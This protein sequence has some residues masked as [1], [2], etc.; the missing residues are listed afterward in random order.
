M[1]T[2]MTSTDRAANRGLDAEVIVVGGGVSGM[3]AAKKIHDAGHSVIVVEARQRVGGRTWSEN[4]PEG[5]LEYGG[6]SVGDTHYQ[7]LELGRS[8]GLEIAPVIPTG[9]DLYMIDGEIIEAPDGQ[10]PADKEY[11]AELFSSIEAL[12]ELAKSVGYEAPWAASNAAELDSMTASSW[13]EQNI[14]HPVVQNFHKT[15]VNFVM[16]SAPEETSMLYWAWFIIQCEGMK[17][18]YETHGGAQNGT[19]I[20]GAN[21]LTIRIAEQLGSNVHLGSPARAVVQ[22]DDY[23]EVETD[24]GT[25]RGRRAVLAMAPV[26]AD[27]LRFEPQLPYKRRQL[28][29][30]APMAR[31]A[32]VLTRYDEPFWFKKGLSG[33]LI[34]CDRLGLFTMDATKAKDEGGLIAGF[35]SGNQHDR[36]AQMSEQEQRELY[37]SILVDA[38]GPE[39]ANPKLFHVVNWEQDPASKGA[40]VMFMPPGVMHP[41]GTAL[42]ERVGNLF[43]AGTEASPKWSGYMEGAVIAGQEA[44]RQILDEL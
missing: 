31:Q 30:R 27:R 25:V 10:L 32:K 1:E 40:P 26:A 17:N 39:A 14:N 19:W 21:Q 38:F 11:S 4:T 37:L 15:T 23:V 29:M 34:D 36:W 44:A 7:S 2:E 28:Q 12:D 43:I 9:I 42:R 41:Y 16:G 24:G 13:I 5:T 22:G 35:V 3:A 20:G 33:G 8:L 18:F 6:M